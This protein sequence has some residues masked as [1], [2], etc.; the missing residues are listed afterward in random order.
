MPALE[1]RAIPSIEQAGDL[2]RE[3]SP[4]NSTYGPARHSQVRCIHG[5]PERRPLQNPS[6]IIYVDDLE[7]QSK[8]RRVLAEDSTRFPG[9]DY[10]VRVTPKA[11]NEQHYLPEQHLKRIINTGDHNDLST[12]NNRSERG[13]TTATGRDRVIIDDEPRL[14]RVIRRSPESNPSFFREQHIDK[15]QAYKRQRAED[16]PYLDP[17]RPVLVMRAPVHKN[18]RLFDQNQTYLSLGQD[19]APQQGLAADNST[20]LSTLPSHPHSREMNS[21]LV[22]GLVSYPLISRTRHEHDSRFSSTRNESIMVGSKSSHQYPQE[23]F[24]PENLDRIA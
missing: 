11:A 24:A 6:N 7:N 21:G 4:V 13:Y 8:R 2:N 14:I 3:M 16:Q 20:Y 22:S 15:P 23:R 9:S 17:G 18:D 5:E 12:H 19:R 1:D 10:Y